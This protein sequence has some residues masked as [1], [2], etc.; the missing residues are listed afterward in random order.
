MLSGRLSSAYII[1]DNGEV[2]GHGIL[3]SLKRSSAYCS[4]SLET[5]RFVV[6]HLM[7]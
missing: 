6:Y 7:E 4:G 1:L 3:G 5:S 2:G